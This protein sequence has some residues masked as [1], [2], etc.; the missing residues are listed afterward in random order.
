MSGRRPRA[1]DLFCRAG[2]I[3]EGLRSGHASEI[4]P[5]N[6][7]KRVISVYGDRCNSGNTQRRA[8]TVTGATPQTNVVHNKVRE[9]FSVE[10]ARA[11][12]GI[13]WMAMKDLSQAIPPVFSHFIG[14]MFL[15]E[16][17]THLLAAGGCMA[18]LF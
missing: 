18:S 13:P 4:S 14:L 9:T 15:G 12:M 8:M 2:G 3:S 5:S 1:L 7:S 6:W 16:D 11:A 17:P 10:E